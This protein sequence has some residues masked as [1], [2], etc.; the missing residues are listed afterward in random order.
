MAESIRLARWLEEEV[1]AHPDFECPAGSPF[2]LVCLRYFPR[3]LRTEWERAMPERKAGIGRRV[4]ALNAGLLEEL[5]GSGIA[6][7]S[8]AVI[9]E[10]Y[11]IRVAVGNIRT[12]EADM[13]RLWDA[14]QRLGPAVTHALRETEGTI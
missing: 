11:V 1:S 9:R 3:D 6:F 10:G 7:A 5:N 14:L 2:A 13:R 4:D 8:H 12:M